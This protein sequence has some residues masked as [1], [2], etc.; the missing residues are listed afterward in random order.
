MPVLCIYS[1]I[2]EEFDPWNQ[3][4]QAQNEKII[5]CKQRTSQVAVLADRFTSTNSI[6]ILQA[7]HNFMSDKITIVPHNEMWLPQKVCERF[8][9][10]FRPTNSSITILFVVNFGSNI[11]ATEIKNVLNWNSSCITCRYSEE[12]NK[13]YFDKVIQ[14]KNKQ[15]KN[16]KN[17]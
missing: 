7:T 11:W 9:P 14:S 12:A 5:M 1:L 8:P 16:T 10:L 13:Q 3:A 6:D 15:K 2:F 17:K 4:T